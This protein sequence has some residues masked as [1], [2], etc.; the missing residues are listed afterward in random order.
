[1]E[2]RKGRNTPGV[3]SHFPQRLLGLPFLSVIIQG[4]PVRVQLGLLV[5]AVRHGIRLARVLPPALWTWGKLF[6]WCLEAGVSVRATGDISQ[7]ARG[8]G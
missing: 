6:L 8:P 3:I 2:N 1:M 4:I 5:V 7:P